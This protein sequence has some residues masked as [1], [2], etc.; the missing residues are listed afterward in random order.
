MVMGNKQLKKGR[1]KWKRKL[2]KT[3]MNTICSETVIASNTEF[4]EQ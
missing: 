2:I 1:K 4:I 3:G